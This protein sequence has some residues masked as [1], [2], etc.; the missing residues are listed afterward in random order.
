MLGTTKGKAVA[1]I[2]LFA[3]SS[4]LLISYEPRGPE[5]CENVQV[6]GVVRC[7][8]SGQCFVLTILRTSETR[9]VGTFVDKPFDVTYRG[10]A[11]LL[12]RKGKWIG[13]LHYKII[14]DCA[15]H[16]Q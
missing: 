16:H 4:L 6:E 11:A 8:R 3:V 14:S 1:L 15:N 13:S 9:L 2:G 5:S 10:P 12:A 7:G